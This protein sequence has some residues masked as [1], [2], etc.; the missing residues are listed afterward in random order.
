MRPGVRYEE[1]TK[2]EL[3]TIS[4]DINADEVIWEFFPRLVHP[5]K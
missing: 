3:S 4:I 5:E 1:T 2:R